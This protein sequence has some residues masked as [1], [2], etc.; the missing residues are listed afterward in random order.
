[1]ISPSSIV[2]SNEYR[3]RESPQ[4]Y[5]LRLLKLA[6]QA[7]TA[8]TFENAI[9]IVEEET[10]RHVVRSADSHDKQQQAKG[11]ID[12]LNNVDIELQQMKHLQVEILKQ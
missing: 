11:A 8:G 1:M 4:N 9:R 3:G 12:A 7:W 6:L 10:A 2:R 5:A